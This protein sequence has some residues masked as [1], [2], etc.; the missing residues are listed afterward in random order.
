M[1]DLS[2]ASGVTAAK[3]QDH[4]LALLWF[5]RAAQLAKEEPRQEE[6][7][8][9]RIANWL[10][11]VCLP[12]ATFTI[13]GFQ[14]VQDH[15]RT[16]EFSPDGRYLLV[17]AS[18]GDCLVWD[19]QHARLVPLP[20]AAAK[21]LAAAW[22]PRTGVLAVAEKEG[23]IRFLASPEFHPVGEVTPSGGITVLAFSRDGRRLAWG[24]SN[25]ARVWDQDKKEYVTPLLAHGGTVDSLSFSAGG[26]LL[27]TSARDSKARVFRIAPDRAEPLFPPV[28][29]QL[30]T[31]E[32][33]ISGGSERIAPR[34]AAD[35]QVLLTGILHRL[36]WR[37]ATT[38]QILMSVDTPWLTAFAVSQEGTQ[39]A[40]VWGGAGRLW[41]ARSRRLLAAI[42][43]PRSNWCE[44]VRFAVDGKTLITGDRYGTVHFWGTADRHNDNLS[45]SS[46]FVSHPMQ[47]LRNALSSD[48]RHLAVALLDGSI[49]LW[50]RPEGPPVAYTAAGGSP[51]LPAVS[52][53]RRLFLP[54]STSHLNATQRVLR[55]YEANSGKAAGPN[56]DPGGILVDA[57]FSPDG[58][59]VA[60]AN[61]TARNS[62]ERN[63]RL[64]EPE[65]KAGNVQFWDWKSGQRVAGPVPLPSEPR[66][67]PTVRMAAP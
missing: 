59:R 43:Q 34:F 14:Q 54:R 63:E 15:F 30:V 10:R 22:Q 18:T 36:N 61:L 17:V 42:P 45:A 40:A 64:F 19:R 7:N 21:G 51:T 5:A 31:M 53:D 46:P 32:G 49:I 27:A 56:I 60:S 20:S 23:P 55:V 2:G 44:E 47:I 58:T 9:I 66:G 13:P 67:C 6:L 41:D 24:G 65:G 57:V 16:V 38:G 26:D 35:D 25:G 52:P 33:M 4:S 62:K 29:Q 12:E 28:E 1:I 3:E 39:V 8:R 50:R 48:S 11:H 37:S